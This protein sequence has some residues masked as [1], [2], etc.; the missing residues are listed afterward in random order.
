MVAS[1]GQDTDPGLILD[2]LG[3][4]VSGGIDEIGL[5]RNRFSMAEWEALMAADSDGLR[6][7]WDIANI[8]YQY[9]D[10]PDD[11]TEDVAL[12]EIRAVASEWM[13]AE[14]SSR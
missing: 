5:F 12:R 4:I 6:V 3:G 13:N 7:G 2:I 14:Q 10:D 9:D 11:V 1:R 8:L